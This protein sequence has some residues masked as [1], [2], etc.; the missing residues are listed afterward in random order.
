MTKISALIQK[1]KS[2][3]RLSV[4]RVWDFFS[5]SFTNDQWISK[6]NEVD[7][8]VGPTSSMVWL[9]VANRDASS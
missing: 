6:V 9:P 3:A 1:E 7:F 5:N 8:P 2:H 4:W